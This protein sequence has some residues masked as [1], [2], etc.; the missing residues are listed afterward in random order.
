[1]FNVSIGKGIVAN[2]KI[3]VDTN[4]KVMLYSTYQTER[5][6]KSRRKER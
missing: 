5:F 6:L 3:C 1:M 4:V 2:V